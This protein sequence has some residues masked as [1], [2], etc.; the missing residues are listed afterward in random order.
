MLSEG[1]L[2][3]FAGGQSLYRVL[4]PWWD[5]FCHYLS[6]MMFM[7]ATLGCT[8]QVTL[9]RIVCIPCHNLCERNWGPKGPLMNNSITKADFSLISSGLYKLDLQQYAYVDA[10]CHEQHLHWFARFFPYVVML[11]TLALVVV[12]NFWFNYPSTSSRLGH[13]VSIL[14]KCCDSPWTTRALS[15]TV[16]EQGGAHPSQSATDPEAKLSATSNEKRFGME[17]LSVL[18]KKEGEQ[19]KAIFEKVKKLKVHVEDKDII[20]H[21]YMKQIIVKMA[22][23]SLILTYVPYAAT[24]ISFEI[25]CMVD[26]RALIPYQSF[27]C[28]HPLAT[29]FW[30]LSLVYTALVVVYGCACFYSFLWMIR[31]SLRQ[32]SFDALRE[33]SSYSDIPDVKN[34][35][36]FILHLLDQYNPL[37][38][39]R[40]S[41]FLSEVSE[42][43]LRQLNLNNVWPLEKLLQKV[44]QNAQGQVELH[45]MLLSGI[46]DAVFELRD[47]E[48][49]KLQ[50]ILEPRLPQKVTQL[51]SLKELWIDH[52]PATVDSMA[53]EFLSEN[54]RILRLKFTGGGK[55]PRWVFRLKNLTELYLYGDLLS[56]GNSDFVNDL[57]KLKNLK[58]LL[59]KCSIFSLP[60]VITN[61]MSSLQKF[62]VDNEGAQLNA[63][64]SLKMMSQLTCLK[65]LNCDLHRIPSSIFSLTN[66]QEIDLRGN[67]LRTIEEIISFQHLQRLFTLKLKNNNINYIPI[68]IGVLETLEQLHLS[69]NYISC[70]PAQLFLCSRLCYLD[71][72]HNKL[73]VIP[74][75]IQDLK[76]LQ[77]LTL[78]QNKIDRLPN[79]LFQCKTLQSLYLDHNSLSTLPPLVSRLT[80]LI[81]LDLRGNQLESLPAELEHCQHLRPGGLHVEEG[82]LNSL[83][84]NVKE[85]FQRPE[86]EHISKP[87][88]DGT[89]DHSNCNLMICNTGYGDTGLACSL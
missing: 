16:A 73:C 34:D 76:R 54:L 87:E 25:D 57:P 9:R 61:S 20:Y 41:V 21:T 18:G 56:V 26:L 12:S 42:K 44:V 62:Y 79:G 88:T 68:H 4:Q 81:V 47:L 39:K 59:L 14:H 23:L 8:L 17:L 2:K 5:V 70:I 60:K 31:N 49:L 45:L 37:F 29:I 69:H 11:Q 65:L 3:K 22:I 30:F 72:S 40:F 82:L 63:T 27:H 48:V 66:L 64:Q 78:S 1:E 13:F 84:S 10:V 43:K 83:P 74:E 85:R 55:A 58:V 80:N 53:L 77:I 71:L 33:E 15:E 50:L 7:I 28:V 35:F 38:S 52:S 36:A 75:G 51:G 19:A 89:A 67:N 32:Y 46:P 6:I 86:K 24:C